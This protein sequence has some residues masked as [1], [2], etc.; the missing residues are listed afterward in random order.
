MSEAQKFIEQ[1]QDEVEN[2]FPAWHIEKLASVL[3]DYHKTQIE[4]I[5]PSDDEVRKELIARVRN[6]G[7]SGGFTGGVDYLKNH[8]LNK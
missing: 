5:M 3:E 7:D 4:K 2:L 6:L 1:K 8:L